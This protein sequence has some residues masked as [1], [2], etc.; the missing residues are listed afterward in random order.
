LDTGPKSLEQPY[1]QTFT[2][3]ATVVERL[4]EQVILLE[5]EER[6]IKVTTP[7][8]LVVAEALL[9]GKK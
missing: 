9:V 6:N 4:G 8:D 7:V 3:E 2:D 1:R 5:G